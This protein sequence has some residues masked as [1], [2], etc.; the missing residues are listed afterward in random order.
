MLC[1]ILNAVV[2]GMKVYPSPGDTYEVVLLSINY[3]FAVVFF[4][5][6]SLKI[7]AYRMT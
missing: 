2:L 5:E 3:L 4:I 7:Y 6:A 1:I